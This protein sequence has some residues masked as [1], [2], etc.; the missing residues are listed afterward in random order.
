M[1]QELVQLPEV[2]GKEETILKP[3]LVYQVPASVWVI[4]AQTRQILDLTEITVEQ[5]MKVLLIPKIAGG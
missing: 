3:E 4:D 5:A 1:K 2:I